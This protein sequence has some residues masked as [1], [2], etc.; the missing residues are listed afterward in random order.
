MTD[1]KETLA[2]QPR[3]WFDA[4]KEQI[5]EC[6]MH[7]RLAEHSRALATHIMDDMSD[8]PPYAVAG[9]GFFVASILAAHYDMTDEGAHEALRAFL[10][11]ARREL[12]GET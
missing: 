4:I 1:D 10:A 2:P 7:V 12:R 5:D 6:L 9:V 11:K 8:Y 3:D